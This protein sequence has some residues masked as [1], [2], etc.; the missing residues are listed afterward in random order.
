MARGAALPTSLLALAAALLLL[1]PACAEDHAPSWHP[2]R[3]KRRER[4][5][6]VAAGALQGT[7]PAATAQRH[8][9]VSAAQRP[10]AA[11]T[12]VSDFASTLAC[13]TLSTAAWERRFC[14]GPLV[15]SPGAGAG[16]LPLASLNV[17]V[18]LRRGADG[19]AFE[20]PPCGDALRVLFLSYRARLAPDGPAGAPAE[21]S[22]RCG[23]HVLRVTLPR[24][25]AAY[26]AELHFL[27]AGGSR[28]D[29]GGDVVNALV[30]VEGALLLPPHAVD[31]PDADGDAF[32][33]RSAMLPA[34]NE[35]RAECDDGRDGTSRARGIQLKLLCALSDCRG[36][37]R[38]QWRRRRRAWPA[39]LPAAG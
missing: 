36:S 8:V 17:T 38:R 14:F 20:A 25:A 1:Q 34:Y 22:D 12:G 5:A 3:I 19:D 32:G 10:A 35:V 24:D 39:T 33:L 30:P 31:D 23:T 9:G 13:G 37:R 18:T 28:P 11:V 27:H 15:V 4:D 21:H 6:A 16:G 7:A 29:D 2:H 26:A